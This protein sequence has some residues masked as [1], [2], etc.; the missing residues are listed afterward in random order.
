MLIRKPFH[1]ISCLLFAISA[2]LF[3]SCDSILDARYGEFPE[4]FDTKSAIVDETGLSPEEQQRRI[5][6]LMAIDAEG[7][8]P[9]TINSGDHVQIIV[10][11]NSDLNINTVVTPDGYIGMVFC[12]QVR[13]AGLTMKEAAE[14]IEKELE[15]YIKN[16]AVGISPISISSETVSISGA[17]AKPGMYTISNGMRLADLYALAG[18]SSVRHFDGQDLDA[19]DLVNSVFIRNSEF[20]EIDFKA[21][22]ERCERWD[23]ILLRKGDYIYIA[24]RSESMVCLVGDVGRPHKRIWDNNLG[25]MELLTTGGWLHET[26]WRY[27]IIIRG[28]TANPHLYKV[29]I[30]G[31]LYGEKPNVM[32]EAGDVVYVPR[33]SISEFNVFVR[34]LMPTGSLISLYSGQPYIRDYVK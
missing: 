7:V 19:A 14:K 27:A 29:D 12:G 15:K 2:L 34:K 20:I 5:E 6:K 13:V 3:C 25:L 26:H 9:Y 1:Y 18:G 23:N 4:L 11:N 28:G 17:V 32:L 8:P 31:I 30:L 21:A 33:D 22:I 24:V 10:Y 16:P